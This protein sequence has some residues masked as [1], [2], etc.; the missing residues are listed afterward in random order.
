MMQHGADIY[1]YAKFANCKP[2]ELIDF[3]SN[4]NFYAL[5]LTRRRTQSAM[6]MQ[7]TKSLQKV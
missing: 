5:P 7:P 4:I 3:S 2:S 6:G 1:T